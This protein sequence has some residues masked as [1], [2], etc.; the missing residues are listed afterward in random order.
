MN[1]KKRSDDV[2]EYEKA[3]RE[4]KEEA[5]KAE[6]NIDMLHE[7]LIYLESVARKTNHEN[8]DKLDM[9]LKRFYVHKKVNSN[10]SFVGS[11]VLAQISTKEEETVLSKEHKV[12]KQYN[13]SYPW[14]Q[15][16]YYS[17]PYPGGYPGGTMNHAPGWGYGGA[18]PQ[19]Q[20][21]F[22]PGGQG[23][24]FNMSQ[25]HAY[26]YQPQHQQQMGQPRYGVN[27]RPRHRQASPGKQMCFRCN[28]PGHFVKN[29][30]LN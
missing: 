30:P 15:Q 16:G 12:Y 6:V 24:M 25:T 11:M 3:K 2:S 7:K 27:S 1:E 29:C 13:M 5:G 9:V 20:A 19:M 10:P 26:M 18:P 4:V 8:K 22:Y 17:G 14:A 23:P 28:K 21:P